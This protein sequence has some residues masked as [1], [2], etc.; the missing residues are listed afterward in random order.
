MKKF[1]TA[2]LTLVISFGVTGSALAISNTDEVT[3]KSRLDII[4]ESFTT[5]DHAS[6][7]AILSKNADPELPSDIFM[8]TPFKMEGYKLTFSDVSFEDS[9]NSE[10]EVSTTANINIK[11]DKNNPYTQVIYF[12]FVME[13]KEWKLLDTDLYTLV[14]DLKS[15]ISGTTETSSSDAKDPQNQVTATKTKYTMDAG[16]FSIL[17]FTGFF[18]I[19]LLLALIVGIFLGVVPMW[20]TFNKAGKPGWASIVPIY[21]IVIMLEIGGLPTWWVLLMFIPFVNF[22]IAI[23]ALSHFLKA[24]GKGTGFL[25]GTIFLPF[26]FI[27]ILGY[28]KSQYIGTPAPSVPNNDVPPPQNP[29]PVVSVPPQQ[30]NTGM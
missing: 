17:A 26:I 24:F 1:L 25:I 30:P 21:N 12:T 11:D 6:V 3:I 5:S 22:V 18:I 16:A 28:G 27:P 7:R 15:Q 9:A 4:A 23:I 10:V 8:V 19:P 29:V 14:K 2:F 13:G 20:K